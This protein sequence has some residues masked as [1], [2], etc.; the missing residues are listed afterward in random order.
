MLL[1]EMLRTVPVSGSPEMPHVHRWV[2][3]GAV[4]FQVGEAVTRSTVTPLK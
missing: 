4:L 2:Q 3:R 1:C